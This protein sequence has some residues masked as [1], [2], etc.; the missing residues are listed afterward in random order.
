[1]VPSSA[2]SV[3]ATSVSAWLSMTAWTF[4][5]EV[6]IELRAADRGCGFDVFEGGRSDAAL[7]NQLGGCIDDADTGPLPL[8]CQRFLLA[9]APFFLTAAYAPQM[10]ANG[11]GAIV[12]VST[13]VAARGM[14]GMAAYGASKAALESLTRAWGAEYGPHGVRVNAVALGPTMTPAMDP[15]IRILD[16]MVGAIPLRRA[17]ESTEIAQAIVFL[18]SEESSYITGAVVPADAGRASV[19]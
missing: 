17:A 18:A 7:I 12:N 14:A 11:G 5:R 10:A 19:L 2:C 13:M 4:V 8:G 3:A 6:V 15:L 9:R 16:D 1:M